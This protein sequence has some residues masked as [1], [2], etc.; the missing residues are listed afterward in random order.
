MTA[1]TGTGIYDDLAT[2]Y[3]L[4]VVVSGFEPVDMMQSVLMLVEQIESGAPKVEVQYNR[5]VH[6]QGNKIA[7]QMMDEVFEPGD[8]QWRGLGVIPK[9]GLR[10][11]KEYSSFDAE[12]QLKVEVPVSTE[13]KGCMCGQILRGLKTPVDCRLFGNKCTPAEPVGACMVSGEGTCATFYKYR[14]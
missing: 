6:N 11:R 8:D 1:I 4:G 10:I 12:M 3:Q 9:S 14:S 2:V 5:V 13:P 7:Q